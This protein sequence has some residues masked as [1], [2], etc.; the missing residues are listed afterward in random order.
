MS[1]RTKIVAMAA[2]LLL[3]V[4][5]A[6]A[7]EYE[8]EGNADGRWTDG[9]CVPAPSAYSRLIREVCV[10]EVDARI[11]MGRLMGEPIVNAAA[12]WQLHSITLA[13]GDNLIPGNSAFWDGDAAARADVLNAISQIELNFDV[14]F[15]F[16]KP[17]AE[18]NCWSGEPRFSLV[19]DVGTI[20]AS[21][22]WSFNVAGS[23][24]WASFLQPSTHYPPRWSESCVRPDSYFEG[25]EARD[26]LDGYVRFA[27]ITVC[28]PEVYGL[29]D[30]YLA[31]ERHCFGIPDA[32][33]ESEPACREEDEEEEAE[34]ER[35]EDANEEG[36]VRRNSLR[37]R[38]AAA[39]G[40]AEE[41]REREEDAA[42]EA[43]VA[44]ASVEA[45]RERD[46]RAA[47]ARRE[48]QRQE[49]AA[50][51]ARAEQ[52]RREEARRRRIQDCEESLYTYWSGDNCE[53][54]SQDRESDARFGV[55]YGSGGAGV[56]IF[57]FP[58]QPDAGQ[59]LLLRYERHSVPDRIVVFF[60]ASGVERKVYDSGLGGGSANLRLPAFEG[61]SVRLVV[62]GGSNGTQWEFTVSE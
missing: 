44:L 57:D 19:A 8:F 18:R 39:L 16:C 31:L 6:L 53:T 42:E 10:Q 38:M 43:Q 7:Q 59:R 61:D 46:R 37:D 17:A 49:E 41:R 27:G 20:E 36:V 5:A 12:R 28:S 25:D 14:Q 33:R 52:L 4:P 56:H 26:L 54:L 55:E 24:N 60:V 13:N 51:Q 11:R 47:A 32:L 1:I 2:C 58:Q 48:R 22:T 9:S 30:L 23:P 45:R 21:D 50:R 3:V 62:T 34:E 15:H 29:A 35:D 40:D